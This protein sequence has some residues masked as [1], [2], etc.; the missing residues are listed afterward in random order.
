MFDVVASPSTPGMVL[1]PHEIA[2]LM[3]VKDAPGRI[4]TG[5]AELDV[6]VALELVM[7]EWLAC[8]Q[9]S[10]RVTARGNTFLQAVARLF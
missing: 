6:L 2:T 3:L 4:E 10:L 5:R 7:L 1:S 8:G 9:A